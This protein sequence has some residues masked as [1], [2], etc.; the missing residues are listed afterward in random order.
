MLDGVIVPLV[1]WCALVMPLVLACIRIYG[2]DGRDVKIVEVRRLPAAVSDVGSPR[3]AVAGAE[4]QKVLV[5]VVG[6]AVPHGTATA[7]FPPFAG[8]GLGSDFHGFL[9]EW[10]RGVARCDVKLP[11]FFAGVRIERRHITTKGRELGAGIADEDFAL[12]G[13]RR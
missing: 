9:F 5:G 3:G 2:D 11:E 7:L 1:A 12:R 4:I 10:L 13:A 6:H 8:P